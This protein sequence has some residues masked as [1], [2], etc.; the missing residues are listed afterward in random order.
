[1]RLHLLGVEMVRSYNETLTRRHASRNV[2]TPCVGGC[3]W[4][5]NLSGTSWT[6][7][8]WRFQ[9]NIMNSHISFSSSLCTH[10]NSI[11][12]FVS[13]NLLFIIIILTM[14]FNTEYRRQ[15]I[16]I[17]RT[18][19]KLNFRRYAFCAS[20]ICV[21]TVLQTV[22][23]NKR[24]HRMCAR[25]KLLT[26]CTWTWALP[27]N[28]CWKYSIFR[29]FSFQ[30]INIAQYLAIS[31]L[32]G[33]FSLSH[34]F[35]N[36]ISVLCIFCRS[37]LNAS[38]SLVSSMLSTKMAAARLIAMAHAVDVIVCIFQ[39]RKSRKHGKIT[40]SNHWTD[41]IINAIDTR[42][43]S[44]EYSVLYVTP[45]VHSHAVEGKN[46]LRSLHITKN[47]CANNIPS[48]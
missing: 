31:H 45:Y 40:F 19:M 5:C 15:H 44:S 7:Y 46:V 48:L 38:Y 43:T 2:F 18:Y 26:D 10:Q 41:F 16:S 37:S 34:S 3:Q 14:E 6:E 22:I 28:C 36:T 35:C 42:A 8:S 21:A 4:K 29:S 33:F 27:V 9:W 30:M 17:E 47:E 23:V 13:A 20:T 11:T 12:R 24:L 1:M 32:T 25:E 39:I